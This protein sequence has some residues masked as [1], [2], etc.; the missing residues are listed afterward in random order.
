ML[1]LELYPAI[2]A[3]NGKLRFFMH[4]LNI[5]FICFKTGTRGLWGLPWNSEWCQAW[6]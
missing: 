6:H 3:L 5:S 4:P 1:T 2:T